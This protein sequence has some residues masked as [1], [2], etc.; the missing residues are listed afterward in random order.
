[1]TCRFTVQM[2]C[3]RLKNVFANAL[4][5][6]LNDFQ[7]ISVLFGNIPNVLK[8]IEKVFQCNCQRFQ[9]MR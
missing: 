1:M 5:Q 8:R 2:R 7:R 9:L 6:F 4:A 3:Q